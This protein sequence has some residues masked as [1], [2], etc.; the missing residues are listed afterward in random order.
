MTKTPKFMKQSGS[1]GDSERRHDGSCRLEA[2]RQ[3]R[4]GARER[5]KRGERGKEKWTR[6]GRQVGKQ[7]S[8]LAGR[9][10]GIAPA[11]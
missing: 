3:V 7:A 1:Q 10:E 11:R 8:K 5:V 2:S 4:I 6:V 9:K